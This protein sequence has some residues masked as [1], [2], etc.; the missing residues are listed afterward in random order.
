MMWDN[1]EIL[2]PATVVDELGNAVPTKRLD[3][4]IRTHGR[5]Q[6]ENVLTELEGR[7]ETA[8]QATIQ[9]PCQMSCIRG[10]TH[11]KYDGH[12]YEIKETSAP[13]PR[14]CLLTVEGWRT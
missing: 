13:S 6:A 4:V 14:W 10:A 12:T 11:I 7:R 3:V 5:L 1:V 8:G 2:R 9:V